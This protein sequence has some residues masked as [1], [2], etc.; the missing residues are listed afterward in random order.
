[1]NGNTVNINPAMGVALGA[2]LE[3]IE[4]L[5]RVMDD[6]RFFGVAAVPVA[7]SELSGI[8]TALAFTEAQVMD[9]ARK[10]LVG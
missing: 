9:R 3:A 7:V 8:R 4:A 6:P 10:G 2:L 5:D 1:M